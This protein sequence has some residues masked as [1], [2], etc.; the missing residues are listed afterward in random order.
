MKGDFE[1]SGERHMQAGV[2]PQAMP[3]LGNKR[4]QAKLDF[5]G[6]E[7]SRGDFSLLALD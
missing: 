6:K 5:W 4:K 1:L 3:I 7:R 2:Q